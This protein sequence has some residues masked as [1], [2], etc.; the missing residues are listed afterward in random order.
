MKARRLRRLGI[1]LA[2]ALGTGLLV[3]LLHVPLLVEMGELLVYESE[4]DHVDAALV[5]PG[6]VP[7]RVL[8]ARDLLLSSRAKIALLGRVEVNDEL[9]ELD[10]LGIHRML[11]HEVNREILIRQG[12]AP[13]QIELLPGESGSTSEDASALRQYLKK[14]N[15]ESIAIV[16]CK[17]HSYRA[18]LNFR[19]SLRGT[20]VTIHSLPSPYCRFDPKSW[21]RNRDQLKTVYLEWAKL[22][23]FWMGFS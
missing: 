23:A 21:W 15:F 7:D 5:L 8:A 3:W 13:E 19:K 22:M 12:I 18:Y 11:D 14:S 1:G 10:E 16:T 20:G 17:Y 6:S 4:F 2:G 9:V